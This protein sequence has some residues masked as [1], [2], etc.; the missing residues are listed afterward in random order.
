MQAEQLVARSLGQN[1]YAA[2][3]IVAHPSGNAQDLCL[4]LDKPAEADALDAAANEI[5]ASLDG[6]SRFQ[7]FKVSKFQ[8]EVEEEHLE[9]L[10]L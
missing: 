4:A 10:K 6:I 9:T 5:T 1:F 2:V 8:G 7:S 3:M